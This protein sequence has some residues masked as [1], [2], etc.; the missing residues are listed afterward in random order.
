VNEQARFDRSVRKHLLIAQS[1]RLRQRLADDLDAAWLPM[2][3]LAEAV[4]LLGVV[5]QPRPW[6]WKLGLLALRWWRQRRKAASP[7]P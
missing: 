3:L 4:P 5:L 1:A 7:R 2:R 6:A